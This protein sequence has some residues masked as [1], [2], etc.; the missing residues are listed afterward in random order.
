MVTFIIARHGFSIYNKERRFTGQSDIPLDSIGHLQAND[1]A[2][3]I[4]ENYKIDKIYSSDLSRAVDTAIPTARFFD[5]P[6]IQRPD[7]REMDLG[8]WTDRLVS[9][10]EV[11]D[12]IAISNY[13]KDIDT[14]P[15]RG[16]ESRDMLISRATRAISEIAAECDGKTVAIFT[17]GGFIRALHCA[18][19]GFDGSGFPSIPRVP[20]A[21]ITVAAYEGGNVKILLES[22]NKHLTDSSSSKAQ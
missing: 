10:I 17:H 12:P 6:I 2:K 20:N 19:H 22:Y 21:A 1:T 9:D 4:S 16:G 14:T 5:L 13:F 11:E 7:L 3:Y 8:I 18:W 15:I